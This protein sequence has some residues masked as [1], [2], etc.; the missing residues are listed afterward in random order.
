MAAR[1]LLA[2]GCASLFINMSNC[3]PQLIVYERRDYSDRCY[4]RIYK[5]GGSGNH[6]SQIQ[7]LKKQAANKEVHNKHLMAFMATNDTQSVFIPAKIITP[8]QNISNP[9]QS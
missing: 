4:P 2:N 8:N 9:L 5:G 7:G 6:T 1:P 3:K